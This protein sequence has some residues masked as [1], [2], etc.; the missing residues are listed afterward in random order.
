M[1]HR[2]TNRRDFLTGESVRKQLR[3]ASE[4]LAEE[5]VEETQAV[6]AAGDTVR[7]ETRAM[8]CAW[9]IILNP[10][11][12]EQVMAASEAFQVVHEL[13]AQFTIYRPESEL[14][15]LNRSALHESWYPVTEN[16]Y[17]L[18]KECQRLWHTTAGAFDPVTRPL[19]SL[20][21][22]CRRNG[23]VP[24]VQ[25]IAWGLSW[26]GLQHVQFD[27]SAHSV[28][29]QLQGTASPPLE[30]G[31][32]LG[33]IGKGYAI[34]AVAEQLRSAAV[35]E[36]L[37][38]GGYSSLWAQGD[39]AGHSGWPVGIQNPLFSERRLATLLLRDQGMSS[40]GSNV[41]FF[42]HEGQRYGHILDPRTGQACDR[43]L[44]V[45]VVAPSA[46]LADA[47]STAFYVMGLDKAAAYCDD[48][49]EVG[50]I[51]IPFPE[52]SRTLSPVVC[53]IADDRLFFEA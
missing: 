28:A 32:D 23:R 3:A 1:D 46:T 50:A 42:R 35:P 31:F 53:N 5:R 2:Q 37:V 30:V 20:W 14:N 21:R 25:E 41:Q 38:H 51:L 11:P 7:L 6:P 48:H 12:P 9:S 13:E 40:S 19:T 22:N 29:F 27:D 10:G 47:L 44:S 17:G 8:A 26:S 33:A 39:H 15:R 18:L 36:F 52:R 45:T 49:P 34:D 43:L 4:R 24:D 16:L